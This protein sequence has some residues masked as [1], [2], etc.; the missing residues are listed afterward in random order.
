MESLPT[1][2]NENECLLIYDEV[3]TGV[4]LTGK[5]WAHEHFGE[6]ACP[7]I[8]YFGKKMQVCGILAGPKLDEIKHNVFHTSSR[9][10]ST[11]GRNLVDMVHSMQIMRIIQAD[12][13]L[14]QVSKLGF[15]F[16]AKL[17]A[18]A[19]KTDKISNIRGLWLFR[20]F[21]F[22]DASMRNKFIQKCFE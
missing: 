2:A 6:N 9:I 4:G 12:N 22:P 16:H 5:F 7:D 20:D 3:Q 21:D 18:L 15:I 17:L 14:E 10:H 8:F 1:L 13:L 19:K 11:W